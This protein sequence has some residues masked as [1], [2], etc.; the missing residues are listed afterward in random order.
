MGSPSDSPPLSPPPKVAATEDHVDGLRR[1]IGDVD[2]D[3]DEV[4]EL[5]QP[6]E[7][8]VD[9]AVVVE[10][11]AVRSP[12]GEYFKRQTS[13]HLYVCLFLIKGDNL[14]L[15]LVKPRFLFL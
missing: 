6:E 9:S 1:T 13:S 14:I 15:P 2:D 12:L 10:A 4:S 5:I 11:Q 3:K 8:R 7:V